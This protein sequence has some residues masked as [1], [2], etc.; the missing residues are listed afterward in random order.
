MAEGVEGLLGVLYN[1]VQD[2]FSL[3]RAKC[4][5]DR[6]RVMDLIEEINAQLPADIEQAHKIV[7]AK[8]QI[9]GDAKREAESIKRSAEE[10]ARQMVSQNEITIQ[11]RQKATEM[12][13]AAEEKTRELKTATNKYVDDALSRAEEALGEAL[14][15]VKS[16]RGRFKS[17]SK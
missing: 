2:G 7:E 12:V 16:S 13:N 5:L 8:N 10:R 1:M 9:I 6:N 4:V 17:V 15:E 14:G 11:A 3:G